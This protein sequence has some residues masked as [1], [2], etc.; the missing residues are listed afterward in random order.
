MNAL[1]AHR[2]RAHA[3]R[4]GLPELADNVT[5]LTAR[6]EQA[7]LGYLDFLDQLLEDEVGAKESRQFR[8][9]LRLSGLPHH[10]GLD[11][12]HF[13]FQLG[14]DARKVKDLAG[15]SFITAKSNI[16]LL[17]P[18]GVGKTM[19]AV[20]LAVA[21][22]QAGCAIYFT[23]LDDLVRKLHAAETAGRFPR[24][25][26]TYLRPSVLVVDEVEYLPLSRE[27]ANTVFQL[28]SMR[29][30]TG[31]IILTS[32][33]P[34]TNGARS[35]ATTSWP[36]PSS[37]ASCTTATSWLSTA[38][39]GDSKTASPSSPEMNPCHHSDR[40]PLL[41]RSYA[42]LPVRSYADNR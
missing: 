7:Q 31:A 8:N 36:P 5:E 11:E 14:L 30:E 28:I 6:A 25:L 2:I 24:Q 10:R 27:E 34:S 33:K 19:F 26:R 21:A 13:A 39:A 23:T 37:T 29:Y 41:V 40:R 16:A 18:P 38:P 3:T 15:L 42:A 22:C 12:F 4:L 17:G 9:A 20:G 32:N 1:I 35:S